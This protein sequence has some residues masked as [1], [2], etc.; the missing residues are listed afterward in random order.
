MRRADAWPH[1]VLAGLVWLACIALPACTTTGGNFDET[2]LNRLVPGQS[3][4]VEAVDALG[5][6]PAVTYPQ[7]DSTMLAHWRYK[8]SAATDALYFRKEAMLQFAGDGRFL[9]VIDTTN[10]LLEP[11]KRRQLLGT[12]ASVP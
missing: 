6:L 1:W 5:A 2:G 10:I 12:G 9:R 7:S 11:W 3:T 8:A 4:Y